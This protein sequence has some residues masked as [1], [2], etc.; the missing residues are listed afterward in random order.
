MVVTNQGRPI[1][2]HLRPGAES[3][4]AVLWAMELDIPQH[5]FYMLMG[6][7]TAST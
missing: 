1:E 4:V 5:H 6:D 2:V 7:T 3:D